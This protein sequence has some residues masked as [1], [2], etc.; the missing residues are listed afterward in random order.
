[1]AA[2]TVIGHTELGAAAAAI[3]FASISSS[4]DHLYLTASLRCDSTTDYYSPVD[5]ELNNDST[6]NYSETYMKAS[7]AT[8]GGGRY[9]TGTGYFRTC[10]TTNANTD[11]DC[12]AAWTLWI[13]NYANTSNFKQLL[14]SGAV[15]NASS[16]NY[17]WH[18]AVSAMLYHSTSAI[19]QVELS[20][21]RYPSTEF[22]QYSSATLYGV[23]G[24]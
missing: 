22:V 16:T 24:A 1:M 5:I 20:A 11:A 14:F 21:L 8:V 23:T 3:T 15:E 2:F 9:S 12:F 6:A 10:W 18:E 19:N 4:Y 7:S 17:R 13:P